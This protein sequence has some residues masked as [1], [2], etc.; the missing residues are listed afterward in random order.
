MFAIYENKSQ[1]GECPSTC[2]NI[3]LIG[4][5]ETKIQAMDRL[6]H[7]G[8]NLKRHDRFVIDLETGGIFL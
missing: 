1:E 8:N 3:V 6:F 5:A 4:T 2:R 7:R